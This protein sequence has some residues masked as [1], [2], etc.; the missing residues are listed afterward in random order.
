[1]VRR[2]SLDLN[3]EHM[4]LLNG[5]EGMGDVFAKALTMGG[6]GLGLARQMLAS[7]G[8]SALKENTAALPQRNGSGAAHKKAQAVDV[9]E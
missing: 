7:M 6:T 4:V 8:D 3:V 1:V 9:S 2:L 5:A